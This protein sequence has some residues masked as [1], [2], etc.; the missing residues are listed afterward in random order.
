MEINVSILGEHASVVEIP[1]ATEGALTYEDKYLRGNNKSSSSGMASL[2]RIIDPKDL[3]PE[4]KDQVVK[5]A[6]KAY[7]KL[8]CLGVSRFDF[9]MDLASNTLYFNELNPVPGSNAFYLWHKTSPPVL[10]THLIDS[11]IEQA[12]ARKITALSQQRTLGFKALSN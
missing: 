8:D 3:A 9:I 2:S 10:Y 11:L 4:I 12:L 1:V 7:A 5:Y 6:L